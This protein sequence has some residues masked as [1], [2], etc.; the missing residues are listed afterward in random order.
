[1]AEFVFR[2]TANEAERF[3]AKVEKGESCWLWTASKTDKGHGVFGTRGRT[4][5]AH[6]LAYADSHES[7]P[8]GQCVL[9]NCPG[10]DHPACVNPTHHY[11]GTRAENNR[12]MVAKGRHVPG[13]TYSQAGY[14][15][16]VAHHGAKMTPA[17]VRKIRRMRELGATYK[18]IGAR[19]KIDPSAAY[20]IA[21]RLS[22]RH[23]A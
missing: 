2:F 9:H 1:M 23:V 4:Y 5:K 17:T 8:H 21:N 22:W 19:F 15:R 10:G 12:D 20:K 11:L 7:I 13:G 16:G 3:W 6:R 18:D 14:R